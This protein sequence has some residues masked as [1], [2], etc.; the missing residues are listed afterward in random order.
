MILSIIHVCAFMGMHCRPS[1]LGLIL[2]LEGI[3]F[4]YIWLKSLFRTGTIYS[5]I[6]VLK[7]K[8]ECQKKQKQKKKTILIFQ[9]FELVGKGQ[10]CIFFLGLMLLH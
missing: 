3:V 5:D 1:K 6:F 10:T 4:Q 2:V 7:N 9:Y 8:I